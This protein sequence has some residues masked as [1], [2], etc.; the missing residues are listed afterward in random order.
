MDI[1]ELKG[2]GIAEQIARVVEEGFS[3]NEETGEVFFTAD[4]LDALNLAFEEKIDSLAG[5]YELYTNKA[6]SLS[7]RSKD[8]AAKAKRFD[9]K[10][11]SVKKYIDMLMKVAKKTKLEVGDK[12]LSYRKSISTEVYDNDKLVSWIEESEERKQAYYT[13]KDPEISKK[14]LGDVLKK[15]EDMVIPGFRLVENNNL[16]IK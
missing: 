1:D 10:A 9:K 6:K 7:E 3:F 13:Y 4:D 16:Q 2:Y 12:S 14:A 5:I 15:N 8:I 11:E